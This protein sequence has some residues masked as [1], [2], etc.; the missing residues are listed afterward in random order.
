ME[1]SSKLSEKH[2]NESKSSLIGKSGGTCSGDNILNQKQELLR[3]FDPHLKEQLLPH[4]WNV[5]SYNPLRFYIAHNEHKQ[6]IISSVKKEKLNLNDDNFNLSLT[7]EIHSLCPT[8]IIIE[9]IPVEVTRHEDPLELSS[10]HKY[11]ITFETQ[12]EKQKTI[13]IGPKSLDEIL[14]ELHNRTLIVE[15]QTKAGEALSSIIL[16]ME[17]D[18]KV[19]INKDVTTPGF[20]LINNQIKGYNIENYHPNPSKEEIAKCLES[21]ELLQQNFKNKDVF[22]TVLKWSI[23]AP[24]NYVMKQTNSNSWMPWLYLYGF[25]RTGKTTL[26]HLE[27]AILG[28]L[29]Q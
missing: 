21:L 20:Y 9:A 27:S 17:K 4:I 18:N 15:Q 5:I 1:N 23:M 28:A 13:T 22:P 6:I 19:I 10:E 29:Q 26:G 24:F 2:S 3:Q 25:P 7:S 16:A 14:Q 12:I 11:T 8:K